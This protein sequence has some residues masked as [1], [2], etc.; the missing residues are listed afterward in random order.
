MKNMISDDHHRFPTLAA[1]VVPGLLAGLLFAQ[2]SQAQQWTLQPEVRVGYEYDDNAR[3]RSDPAE[4]QEVDGYLLEGSLGIAYNTQRT[5]FELTPRL[6]SRV[7]DEIPDV[8]SDDQ[9]LDFDFTHQTLKGL[10][11]VRSSYDRESVRTAERADPDFDT[12]DPDDIPIDE[13]GDV[14]SNERRE[15]FRIAPEWSY[16]FTERM[17]VG[18]EASYM[19]VSYDEAT[20][21][22]HVDYT[23]ARLAATLGR[24]FTERTYG[25]VGAGVRK[26]ENDLGT[27]DVDGVDA[28]IGIESDI[29]QTTRLRA[30][31]G[32]ENTEQSLTGESDGNV[33]ANFNIVRRLETI[34]MLAQ[35]RRDIAGTGAGRVTARDSVNFTL[36]KQ[37]TERVS[38]GLGVRAFQSEE[39]GQQDVS[40]LEERDFTEFRAM[41]AVALS[42]AFTVEGDY[43]YARADRS[44]FEDEADGNSIMVWLVYRPT[45]IVN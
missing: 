31:I 24:K 18:L 37:F 13:T 45:A 5:T 1:T 33:V 40:T 38:G 8:D 3:L 6:R 43:R 23:D 19:D 22:G 34:T 16:A 7:Y 30:E 14:F 36:R 26:Y 11:R 21:D 29:S 25:Y 2:T 28:V 4:I 44:G 17:T 32:Y 12:D 10:F 15:R 42:R 9:F 35:Y 27:N 39:V 20:V 41:L